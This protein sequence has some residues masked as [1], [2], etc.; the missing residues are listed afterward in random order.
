MKPTWGGG[1][2]NNEV[3]DGCLDINVL[4]RIDGRVIT[5]NDV[6]LHTLPLKYNANGEGIRPNIDME[7]CFYRV[8]RGDSF[9]PYA[10]MDSLTKLVLVEE[11]PDGRGYISTEVRDWDREDEDCVLEGGW[12][13][14]FEHSE[15]EVELA[16]LVVGVA[17]AAASSG[18]GGKNKAK[19]GAKGRGGAKETVAKAKGGTQAKAPK[20]TVGRKKTAATKT[21]QEDVAMADAKEAAPK[22]KEASKPAASSSFDL[23]AAAA[24]ALAAANPKPKVD[25]KAMAEAIAASD[26]EAKQKKGKGAKAKENKDESGANQ[27][28]RSMSITESQETQFVP[29]RKLTA[30][31][32]EAQ[33]AALAKNNSPKKDKRGRPR[34]ESQESIAL[35]EEAKAL[36]N[37]NPKSPADAKTVANIMGSSKE[38]AAKKADGDGGKASSSKKGDSSS[39][40]SKKDNADKDQSAKKDE[41]KAKSSKKAAKVVAAAAESETKDAGGDSPKKSEAS[42]KKSKSPAAKKDNGG[43]EQ[44][45]KKTKSS[46]KKA[47]KLVSDVET[48]SPS[49]KKAHSADNIPAEPA[50]GLAKGWTQKKIPR[51]SGKGVDT[52]YFSPHMNIRCRSKP[53]AKKLIAK[54]EETGGDESAAWVLVKE[55]EKMEKQEKKKRKQQD[56]DEGGDKPAAEE[57]TTSSKKKKSKSGK[58]K[59]KAAEK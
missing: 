33:E 56:V 25:K 51:T 32:V 38:S 53:E 46:K 30:K 43:D 23:I 20:A 24:K 1:T 7:L 17:T 49:P 3:M 47:N 12:V 57:V 31:E 58:K 21:V 26:K 18:G 44:S 6:I 40:K 39:K 27:R 9:G 37:A 19:S 2:S 50:E 52:Y 54:V 29:P 55:D 10:R 13:C 48:A 42:S 41:K 8:N 16:G 45:A 34:S 14:D 4:F 22:N 35:M 28:T 59:E 15:E 11:H 36:A 5:K